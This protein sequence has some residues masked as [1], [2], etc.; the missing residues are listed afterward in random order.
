MIFFPPCKINLGL[1]IVSRRP[2]GFH[3]LETS[4]Y[5]VSWSDALE[6][7][8]HP[9]QKPFEL[10]CSGLQI[11]AEGENLI[12]KAWRL[13]K[14]KCDVPPVQVHL[15]KK[16]PMGAGLGG[17]SAD[18]AYFLRLMKERFSLPVEKQELREIAA[19]L[20]SD[21]VFFL[22]NEPMLASGKG[23]ELESL[24]VSLERFYIVIVYAGIHSST[25]EAYSAIKP[26]SPEYRPKDVLKLP[27]EEWRGKL[28]NDFEPAIFGKYPILEKLK[29]GL[30]KAGAVYASM[31]GSGSAIFGLFTHAPELNLPADHMVYIQQP[32]K[33]IFL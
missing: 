6:V 24:D 22:Q 17:G 26:H 25:R 11:P 32:G 8:P 18:A 31:S 16:I 2:G 9:A 21:C 4:F 7:I 1:N 29:D 20:G 13:L 10:S 15:L 5:P 30:Y 23:D 33:N 27:P 14:E 12:E 3:N 19:R 28:K